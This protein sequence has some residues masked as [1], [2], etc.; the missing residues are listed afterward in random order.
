LGDLDNLTE[1]LDADSQAYF[2][3]LRQLGEMLLEIAL[4]P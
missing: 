4:Q 2:L 3:R 1:D